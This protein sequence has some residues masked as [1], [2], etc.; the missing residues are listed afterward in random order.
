MTLEE[1]RKQK[2]IKLVKKFEAVGQLETEISLLR[3]NIEC[4]ERFLGNAEEVAIARVSR[5]RHELLKTQI[6]FMKNYEHC[7]Y[8]R[9]EEMK[10]SFVS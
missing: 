6:G 8:L 10:G 9:I 4:I 3:A 1:A 2:G 5:Y 7:L